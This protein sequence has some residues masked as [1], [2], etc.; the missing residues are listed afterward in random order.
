MYIYTICICVYVCV[1]VCVC[2]CCFV[3]VRVYNMLAGVRSKMALS[4]YCMRPCTFKVCA[5]AGVRSNTV[6]A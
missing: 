5:P 6:S 2:V 4:Y 1:C 3:C